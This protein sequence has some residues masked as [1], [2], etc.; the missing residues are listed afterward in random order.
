MCVYMF[1]S[2]S[3]VCMYLYY[4]NEFL[5]CVFPQNYFFFWNKS[6][7]SDDS[8]KSLSLNLFILAIGY[9]AVLNS[10]DISSR[11]P[12]IT[13]PLNTNGWNSPP[14]FMKPNQKLNKNQGRLVK[15]TKC[16]EYLNIKATKCHWNAHPAT[17]SNTLDTSNHCL[18]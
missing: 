4:I 2:N 10:R 12:F 14:T 15:D 1:V 13:W 16:V 7:W 6:S 9:D 5:S 18:Y 8:F 11:Q 3:L 17:L